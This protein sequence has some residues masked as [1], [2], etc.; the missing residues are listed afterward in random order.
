[1]ATFRTLLLAFVALFALL[2]P[3]FATGVCVASGLPQVTVADHNGHLPT[4]CELQG[5]KRIA[6]NAQQAAVPRPV[7][8]PDAVALLWAAGLMDDLA[9]AGHAV[10]TELP[11]PR[12]G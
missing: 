6:A 1:M 7:E 5:G 12:F 9:I 3:S 2:T 10:G 11:P 4:P 8:L